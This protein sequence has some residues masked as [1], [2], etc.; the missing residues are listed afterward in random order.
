LILRRRRRD[1]L[2]DRRVLRRA[3]LRRRD[4][5]DPWRGLDRAGQPVELRESAGFVDLDGEEQR[6][7]EARPEPLGEEV[8]RLAS[9]LR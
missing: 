5:G 2:D 1:H 4:G 8:V 6:P 7:V 3:R 9:R